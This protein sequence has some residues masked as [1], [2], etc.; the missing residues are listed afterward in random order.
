[1][2]AKQQDSPSKTVTT[3]PAELDP[4]LKKQV[5][6]HLKQQKIRL[7]TQEK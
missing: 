3:Q 2:Q 4:A 1:M 7:S 5:D 6:Q